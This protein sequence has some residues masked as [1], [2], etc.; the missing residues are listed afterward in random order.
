MR[1]PLRVSPV[2]RGTRAV[3]IAVVTV[4]AAQFAV[5]YVPSLQQVFETEAVAFLDG[6][7]ITAIGVALF[8]I[9]EVEKQ[10]RLANTRGGAGRDALSRSPAASPR[11][12]TPRPP[13]R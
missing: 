12:R 6:V 9:I 7:L 5:T 4:T 3:W 11:R 13:G 1:R 2:V 10:L 8:A